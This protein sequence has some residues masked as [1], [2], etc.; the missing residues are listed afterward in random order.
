MQKLLDDTEQV[1]KDLSKVGSHNKTWKKTNSLD[2]VSKVRAQVRQAEDLIER[3][4]QIAGV[5]DTILKSEKTDKH[6]KKRRERRQAKQSLTKVAAKLKSNGFPQVVADVLAPIASA[7]EHMGADADTP[8]ELIAVRFNWA[9]NFLKAP[10]LKP[11]LWTK[12]CATSGGDDIF[13]KVA[14][15]VVEMLT[16]KGL[17]DTKFGAL[18][19]HLSKNKAKGN[20]YCFELKDVQALLKFE[21]QAPDK[22]DP[23]SASSPW[24]LCMT[25]HACMFGPSSVPMFGIGCLMYVHSGRI[26]VY[27]QDINTVGS[28]LS[29]YL[30][31]LS[32]QDSDSDCCDGAA[33][34]LAKEGDTF[35]AP[36]AWVVM[37]ASLGD[38]PAC[39]VFQPWLSKD[40]AKGDSDCRVGPWSLAKG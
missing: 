24:L 3:L 10:C 40:L 36:Y 5:L 30:D 15:S 8:S 39:V 38:D 9:G 33:G 17:L 20:N 4:G 14:R 21:G 25:S 2:E 29:L 18:K 31:F 12:A 26:A 19:A 28:T 1:A 27:M 7:A 6:A 11:A 32:K 37:L 34:F 23:M 22:V 35:W 13:A 16:S